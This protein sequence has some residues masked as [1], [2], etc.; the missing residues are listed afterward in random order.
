MIDL[1]RIINS[2]DTLTLAS[3]PQGFAP[4]LL[5]DLARAAKGRTLF[6]APDDAAMRAIADAHRESAEAISAAMM[7][8]LAECTRPSFFNKFSLNVCM[9]MDRRLIPKA[10]YS[11][12]L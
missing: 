2:R 7:A 10:R 1:Q 12:N 4:L 5:A 11:A 8:S 6:V 9:P 3:V